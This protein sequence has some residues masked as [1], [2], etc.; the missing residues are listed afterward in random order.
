MRETVSTSP[1]RHSPKGGAGRGLTLNNPLNIRRVRGQQWR[2]EE[3]LSNSSLKGENSALPQRESGEETFCR[4]ASLEWGIR[5]AFRILRTYAVVHGAVCIRD[6]IRRW[7]PP[8]ENN[9]DRYIRN[10][11][12]WTGLSPT[13]P[14][15]ESDWPVLV[16]AMA[17][18]ECG[19][20]LSEESVNKAFELYK[21]SL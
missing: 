21:N 18:Q 9:T 6:I 19:M 4:F 10:V 17:R 1:I 5:A 13:Q 16:R 14:L 11:C 7:A 3:T 8:T 15:S 2:G 20:L 12:Q